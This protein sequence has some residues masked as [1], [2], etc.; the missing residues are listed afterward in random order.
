MVTSSWLSQWWEVSTAS[1]LGLRSEKSPRFQH[2]ELCVIVMV[3]LQW[4]IR[5]SPT[6]LVSK[7]LWWNPGVMAS[8]LDRFGKDS[9]RLAIHQDAVIFFTPEE[10]F[11]HNKSFLPD[12]YNSS[13]CISCL[14]Y[15]FMDLEVCWTS[16]IRGRRRHFMLAVILTFLMGWGVG[17][18]GC[19]EYSSHFYTT[20]SRLLCL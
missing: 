16:W 18:G 5:G 7:T 6:I 3:P 14:I 2:S 17:V 9:L 12:F 20:F 8:F 11:Y 4:E 19:N 13:I 15:A 10:G 1:L